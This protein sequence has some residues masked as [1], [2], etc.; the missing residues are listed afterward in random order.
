MRTSFDP[1]AEGNGDLLDFDSV[2]QGWQ[3]LP[4]YGVGQEITRLC[5]FKGWGSE[6]HAELFGNVVARSSGVRDFPNNPFVS[7]D[8][9]QK[10]FQVV[11]VGIISLSATPT[12]ESAGGRVLPS[13]SI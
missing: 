12:T 5:V 7:I 2:L 4:A 6:Q 10:I 1:S 8:D 11:A 9:G 3:A 13:C